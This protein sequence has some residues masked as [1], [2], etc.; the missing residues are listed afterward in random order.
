MGEQTIG[1]LLRELRSRAGRSQA[2]QA[3]ALSL[4]AGQVVTR[5]EVSR[6]EREVRL[7]T[8]FWQKHYAASLNVPAEQ[9][10]RAVAATK[11]QRRQREDPVQRRQFIS[12]MAGLALPTA[13][14]LPSRV[15]RADVDRLARH[16][17]R[18]RRMDNFMG[19][20]DTYGVY[21]QEAQRT[22]R[23]LSE[24]GHSDTVGR[25]LR[26]LLAEQTQ[27]AGWAAFDAGDHTTARNHYRDSYRA[28]EEAG[29]DV[30]AGNALAFTAYQ[31]TVT[32]SRG[33]DV[34]EASWE[35]AR[36]AATPRVAA[37]L[38]ERSAWAHAVAGDARAADRGLA[39]AREA[40]QRHDDRP[41]PDWVFWVDDRE[42]DIMAGRCWTELHRPLRA[43]PVLH[44]VLN[45]YD[46]THARDKALY[47]TWLAS[48]YLQAHEVE[49]A[50]AALGRAFDLA[51]GVAS[52]R[53]SA[54][55]MAE[56]RRLEPHWRVPEV[57]AL[58]DRI[59]QGVVADSSHAR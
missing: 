30:L 43:V 46:D 33:A 10:R 26:S 49:Q 40:L 9:L 13:E 51:A 50:A 36:R 5:H 8:P 59:G 32:S 41:E 45:R 7:L 56:A 2:Q 16:T 19:G 44:D 23:L 14:G 39:Q 15:G 1:M 57:T 21:A 20:G 55:I 48:S 58:L 42:L 37:L 18:L 35:K 34:A 31:Q 52:V 47:L 12:V 25:A 27:L 28:A 17:A 6:W 53:P 24:S 38:L 54:R 11:A 29:D 4:Q 3:E 22:A